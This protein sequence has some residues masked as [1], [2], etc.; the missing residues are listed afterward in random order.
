LFDR[1]A[2]PDVVPLLDAF[3]AHMESKTARRH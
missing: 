2:M 1:S 3:E